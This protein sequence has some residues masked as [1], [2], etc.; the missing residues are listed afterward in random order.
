MK[1]PP[2]LN[3]H[4]FARVRRSNQAEDCFFNDFQFKYYGTSKQADDSGVSCIAS[5]KPKMKHAQACIVSN[6]AIGLRLLRPNDVPAG[7]KKTP[8]LRWRFYK[9]SNRLYLNKAPVPKRPT[10]PT[11][12]K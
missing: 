11:I 3:I 7:H 12:I 10:K 2:H 5:Y 9:E 6:G 4:S 1:Q 8:P